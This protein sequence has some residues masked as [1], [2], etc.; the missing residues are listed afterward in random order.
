[1]SLLCALLFTATVSQRP[2]TNIGPKAAPQ[3]PQTTFFQALSALSWDAAKDGPLICVCP[4]KVTDGKSLEEL[5]M[6]EISVGDITAI[7]PARMLTIRSRFTEAPNLYEGLPTDAKVLYLLTI[8]SDDQVRKLFGEGLCIDDCR[9]EAASVMQ[10]ILP[11]PLV[12]GEGTTQNYGGNPAFSYG[13]APK[14][15]IMSDADRRRVRIRVVKHIDLTV[16]LQNEGGFTGG[17]FHEET[18]VG[19]VMPY[20]KQDETQKFGLKY[21][22][23]SDN[24]PRKSQ[25]DF[26]DA[27]LD[28]KIALKSGERVSSLLDRISSATGLTLRCATAY[29]YGETLELGTEASA[30]DILQAVARSVAGVYRKLGNNYILTCDLEGIR[31][32][33]ARIAAYLDDLQKETEQ[34]KSIWRSAMRKS[35]RLARIKFSGNDDESLTAAET[36]SMR[37]N[38]DDE[39][40]GPFYLPISQ[41]SADVRKAMEA[42]NGGGLNIDKS[43]VGIASSV[44][45]QFVMPNGTV[46]WG[47]QSVGNSSQFSGEPYVWQPPNPKPIAMPLNADGSLRALVLRA[48]SVS[49]AK[50]DVKQVQKLGLG[51]LWLETQNPSVLKAAIEAGSVANIHVALVIRPWAAAPGQVPADPD[52]TTTGDH[53]RGEAAAIANYQS[54]Q[55]FYEDNSA[56]PSEVREN[57]S[58]L[59]P[60]NDS[61]WAAYSR[62]ADTPGVSKVVLLDAYPIGYAKNISYSSRDYFFAHTA[63]NFVSYGYSDSQR[64]AFLTQTKTDPVDTENDILMQEVNLRDVWNGFYANGAQPQVWQTARSGW[65]HD[66]L[67]KL[68]TALNAGGHA[69]FMSGQY[70]TEDIPPFTD[71]GLFAWKPGSDLPLFPT[72][73]YRGSQD[74]PFDASVIEILDDGDPAARNRVANVVKERLSTRKAPFALDFSSIPSSKVDSVVAR[75][76]T[77]SQ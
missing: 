8:A 35:G 72:N 41:A 24:L 4:P 34:R 56:Y 43:K 49:A 11:N 69:I 3:K 44:R 47:I 26:G 27:R 76:L 33:Q 45:Y 20:I 18:S 57:Y 14:V 16:A 63:D 37:K 10:S 40:G 42:N 5:G 25:L 62:L 23:E 21:K 77:K 64:L 30:R 65:I 74:F 7:G 6:K 68:V 59:D 31:V 28:K 60:A 15:Q 50:A 54:L 2:V 52:R 70:P 32:H 46:C 29:Q 39:R 12:W 71:K 48:D 17:F 13:V 36:E 1:M 19:K 66:S 22:L 51:E 9:G 58:P 75:W 55:H 67:Q 61:R 38:D 53:G 73:Y